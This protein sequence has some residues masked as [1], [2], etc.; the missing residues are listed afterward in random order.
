MTGVQAIAEAG[1]ITQDQLASLV[2][3]TDAGGLSGFRHALEDGNVKSIDA[4]LRGLQALAAARLISQEQ[5]LSFVIGN[6]IRGF[7]VLYSAFQ[8][9]QSQ[10]AITYVDAV[11]EIASYLSGD[12][13]KQ[14][15]KALR[16]CQG[17]RHIWSLGLLVN[18]SHYRRLKSN[19]AFYRKFKALKGAL[20]N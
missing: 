8:E 15:L 17:K 14:L 10:A 16:R 18:Y 7:P 1:L 9:H 5:L 11:S 2:A 3:A 6:G 4:Y 20:K 12:R 19:Q 13:R